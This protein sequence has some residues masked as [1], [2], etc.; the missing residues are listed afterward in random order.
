M[1]ALGGSTDGYGNGSFD[2]NAFAVYRTPD[3]VLSLKNF[4]FDSQTTVYYLVRVQVEFELSIHSLG[5]DSDYALNFIIQPNMSAVKDANDPKLEY[6][7]YL[8][9]VSYNRDMSQTDGITTS[10]GNENPEYLVHP[11]RGKNITSDILSPFLL[12]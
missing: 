12:V 6:V 4:Y 5:L 8:L 3:Q 7:Y 9:K 1:S 10:A 11:D 2:K